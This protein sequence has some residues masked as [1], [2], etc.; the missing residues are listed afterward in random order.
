MFKRFFKNDNSPSTLNNTVGI[1]GVLN[2][3]KEEIIPDQRIEGKLRAERDELSAKLKLL[4]A[5]RSELYELKKTQSPARSNRTTDQ[6]S[7]LNLKIVPLNNR[8]QAVEDAICKIEDSN[9][10]TALRKKAEKKKLREKKAGYVY[11]V[12]SP[13][14]PELCKVGMT[15]DLTRRVRDLMTDRF[16]T[17]HL[18]YQI[19]F[20]IAHP[21]NEMIEYDAH[22]ILQEKLYAGEA[23]ECPPKDAIHAV[24]CATGFYAERW[25]K[26]LFGNPRTVKPL[27][28]QP[29]K[30][31]EFAEPFIVDLRMGK[32]LKYNSWAEDIRSK[33]EA[34]RAG[35]GS[36][37]RLMAPV[38]KPKIYGYKSHLEKC[39]RDFHYQNLEWAC[40]NIFERIQQS[41][42]LPARSVLE[43]I[44]CQGLDFENASERRSFAEEATEYYFSTGYARRRDRAGR[45]N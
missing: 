6:I 45:S 19:V 8:L 40:E 12:R 44:A 10:T 31:A 9:G 23:F 16:Y 32:Y 33:F 21:A 25:R 43:R 42:K 37:R 7:E 1:Q 22:A 3:G 27:L 11:V 26:G 34:D 18:P 41:R 29:N 15:N 36:I 14:T 4:R 35:Q 39:R 28:Q 17:V 38:P 13:S 30:W 2:V 24:K 20:A 5:R